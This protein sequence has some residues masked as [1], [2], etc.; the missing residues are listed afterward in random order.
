MKTVF[1]H[2][3]GQ[4]AQDWEGVIRKLSFSDDIYCPELFATIENDISYS[5]I[6]DSLEQQYADTPEPLRIC[7][8]SLGAMLALDFTIRHEDKVGSLILIGA[9]YKVPRLLIDFQNLLFRCMPNKSFADMGISKNNMIRLCQSMRSLDFTSQ[10]SKITCPVTIVCGEKDNANL[11]ASKKLKELLPQAKLY[12][13]PNEGHEINKTAPQ[14][15]A[16]I[17]N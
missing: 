11:K 14:V 8:L 13:I 4:T 1:L 12:V 6:M 10:I 3:L 16:D 2:G 7:G 15:I 17:L 9:Q 5:R